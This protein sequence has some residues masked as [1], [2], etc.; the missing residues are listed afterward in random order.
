[1]KLFP[2]Q[3]HIYTQTELPT[4]NSPIQHDKLRD[5][6]PIS[7][8]IPD[9]D[10]YK[11]SWMAEQLWTLVIGPSARGRQLVH[12]ARMHPRVPLPVQ[13]YSD[14]TTAIWGFPDILAVVVVVVFSA[15]PSFRDWRSSAAILGETSERVGGRGAVGA[16]PTKPF[17]FGTKRLFNLKNCV[18]MF[19]TRISQSNHY[20]FDSHRKSYYGHVCALSHLHRIIQKQLSI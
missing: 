8:P 6:Y 1:M 3:E 5:P 20:G 7:I 11:L 17:V 12:L 4:Q 19:D 13:L 15:E 16:F 9:R 2:L 10:R 18:D 14:S